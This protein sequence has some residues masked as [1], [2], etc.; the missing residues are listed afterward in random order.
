MASV[1]VKVK[2]CERV[3]TRKNEKLVATE[4]VS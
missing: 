4:N 3:E 1:K 2:V